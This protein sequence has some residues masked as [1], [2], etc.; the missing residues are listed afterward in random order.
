V[1][2]GFDVQV[3]IRCEGCGVEGDVVLRRCS[4]D[5][6]VQEKSK[7]RGRSHDA[8]QDMQY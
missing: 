4:G 7:H 3:I 5:E 8:C 2:P 1:I 6:S